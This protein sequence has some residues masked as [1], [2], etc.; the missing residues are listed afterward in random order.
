[1]TVQSAAG[2]E[3][4]FYNA[5][6]ARSNVG[7]VRRF[8]GAGGRRSE[9]A[10]C[11]AVPPP[12]DH[13]LRAAGRQGYA[14]GSGRTGICLWGGGSV[15]A[16]GERSGAWAG[17]RE[18]AAGSGRG[19][20][21]ADSWLC[22]APTRPVI[23]QERAGRRQ[24][25]GQQRGGG[26]RWGGGHGQPGSGRGGERRRATGASA[27]EPGRNN[28]RQTTDRLQEDSTAA[29]ATARRHQA[30]RVPASSAGLAAVAQPGHSTRI[31]ERR[32]ARAIACSVLATA[33]M[34]PVARTRWRRDNG[35]GSLARL[36]SGQSLCPP[37][38]PPPP[39]VPLSPIPPIPHP[40]PSPPSP[41]RQTRC[42]RPRL[43]VGCFTI[44]GICGALARASSSRTRDSC[45]PAARAG[46]HRGHAPSAAPCPPSPARPA[47]YCVATRRAR[48]RCTPLLHVPARV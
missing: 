41:R 37:P 10:S 22:R 8:C 42:K 38:P 39:F 9:R 15:T 18:G 48:L 5:G 1:M 25:G 13:N 44:C 46:S 32:Q 35:E 2:G 45:S 34:A 28:G 21:D 3:W 36:S 33:G 20:L 23:A 16:G 4:T 11:W 29:M 30:R 12:P 31:A 17:E 24:K 6:D 14:R 26:R 40:H 19:G 47:A 7:P 27:Q 43:R